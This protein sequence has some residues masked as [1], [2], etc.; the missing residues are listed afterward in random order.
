M[1]AGSSKTE[2]FA[3]F[4]YVFAVWDIFYYVFLKLLLG[5]PASLQT[6][7]ILFLLPFT[8]AGPVMGPVINSVSMIALAFIIIKVPGD[9]TFTVLTAFEWFLL[10]TGSVI[11]IVAYTREYVVFMLNEFSFLE[12]LNPASGKNLIEY[13][14]SFIPSRFD[15]DI[16]ISGVLLHWLAIISIYLRKWDRK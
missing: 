2:R 16:F 8:W 9:N 15:W 4:I 6:W 5:W 3:W 7:D 1:L 12:L 14:T 10:I 13:A 11:V